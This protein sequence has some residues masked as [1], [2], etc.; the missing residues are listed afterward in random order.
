MILRNTNNT[1]TADFENVIAEPLYNANTA[2]TIG[3][4]VKSQTD[5]RRLKII[6]TIRIKQSQMADLNTVLE[7]YTLEMFYTPNCKLYDRTTI[8]E[9][10]VIMKSNPKIKERIYRDDKIFYVTLEFEEVLPE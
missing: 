6:S 4:I 9:I 3:G 1:F 10:S 2:I 7:N 5:S 8:E